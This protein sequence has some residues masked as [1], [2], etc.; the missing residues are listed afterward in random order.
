[1]WMLR[2]LK[3]SEFLNLLSLC[4]FAVQ[5]WCFP[6]PWLPPICLLL[7][8]SALILYFLSLLKL[9]SLFSSSPMNNF[10]TVW[11]LDQ[12]YWLSVL[13]SSCCDFCPIFIFFIV[14]SSLCSLGRVC[15]TF[16]A[17]AKKRLKADNEAECWS[18]PPMSPGPLQTGS[19]SVWERTLPRGSTVGKGVTAARY[20]QGTQSSVTQKSICT[21]HR[22]QDGTLF[23]WYWEE[24][25]C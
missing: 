3:M 12:A 4:S 1:M 18:D 17:A 13:F 20:V 21:P 23:W 19:S 11:V 7:Y 16:G 14:S 24:G 15:C 10:M 9:S 22:G 2:C 5:L 8:S 25:L 6:L